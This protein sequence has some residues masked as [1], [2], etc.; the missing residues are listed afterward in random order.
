MRLVDDLVDFVRGRCFVLNFSDASFSV[1]FASEL[2]VNIDAPQYA[3]HGGS[4]GKQHR[5]FF[6]KCDASTAVRTLSAFW[7]QPKSAL[8]SCAFAISFPTD[9]EE[10]RGAVQ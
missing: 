2:K 5:C 4:K 10:E 9:R 8:P 6:Q 3:E 7:E 1:F